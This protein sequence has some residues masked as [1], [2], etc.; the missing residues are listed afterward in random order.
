MNRAQARKQAD[1]LH[2]QTWLTVFEQRVVAKLPAE[3]GR[4]EWAD[5]TFL[6]NS[7]RSIDA[8]V[9][10]YVDNRS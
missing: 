8:A 4:I 3:R 2:R 1:D 5:A 6:Y 10:R 7:G 9:Q